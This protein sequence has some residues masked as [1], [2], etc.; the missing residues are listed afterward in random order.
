MEIGRTPVTL[1][2]RQ[3]PQLPAHLSAV[4]KEML[5]VPRTIHLTMLAA[6]VIYEYPPS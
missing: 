2:V 1:Q 5:G 3:N 6:C 4:H